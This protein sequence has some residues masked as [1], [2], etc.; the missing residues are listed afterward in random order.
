MNL[1]TR[2]PKIMKSLEIIIRR[3]GQAN[4]SNNAIVLAYYALMS[5]APIILIAG[6]L[7]AR[8]DLKSGKARLAL[9]TWLKV[10]FFMMFPFVRLGGVLVFCSFLWPLP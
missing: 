6:N 10:L 7:I 8:F 1:K 2:Y 5:I 4:V 9:M 3:Y